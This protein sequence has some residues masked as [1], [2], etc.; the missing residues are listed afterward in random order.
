MNPD[1]RLLQT[2]GELIK[3]A[4]AAAHFRVV[5]CEFPVSVTPLAVFFIE[6]PVR[7]STDR[8]IIQRHIAALANKL[9]WET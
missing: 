5:V 8:K 4:P 7:L 1:I 6:C 9:P 2:G 3:T